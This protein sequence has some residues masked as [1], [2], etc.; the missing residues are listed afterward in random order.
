MK[1]PPF[2]IPSM[3]ERA[4]LLFDLLNVTFFACRTVRYIAYVTLF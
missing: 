2:V 1:M 3:Q 4:V